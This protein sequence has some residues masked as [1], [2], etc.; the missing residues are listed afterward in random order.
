MVAFSWAGEG[1]ADGTPLDLYVMKVDHGSPVR[2]TSLP[3]AECFP[4][5]SPD[6]TEIAF[7]SEDG[8]RHE[9]C[10][11]PVL[12]GTV[13]RLAV[14]PAQI[15]GLSWSP[16]GQSLAYAAGDTREAISRIRVLSLANLSVRDLTSPPPHG[17]GDRS[18]VFSPD[19]R[20]VAFVRANG[21]REQDALVVPTGGGEA[22]RVEMGG[23]RVSGID[24][25]SPRELVISAAS[26]IDYGLWRVRVGSGE[27]RRMTV[28]AGRI[29]RVSMARGGRRLAYE[30]ISFARDIRCADRSGT[31]VVR[32]RPEPL[33]TSTQRQS[34][35]VF[36]PDGR[37]IAFVSDRSGTPEIW[38]AD[39]DGRDPRRITDHEATL[40]TTPRW[41]P[42]GTQVAYTCDAGGTPTVYV[43]ALASRVARRLAPGGTQVLSTWSRHGDAV[44]YQ[45]DTG[46]GWEVWRVRADGG[47]P[48]KIGEADFAVIDETADGQ[49]LLGVVSGEPGIW[50]VPVAG[51]PKT[52]VVPGELC[53]DWQEAIVAGDGMYFLRR[54]TARFTLGFLRF[55]AVR[56]DSL[57]SLEWYAASLALS[58]DRSR[59]LYD[60]IGGV[61]D[62][63]MVADFRK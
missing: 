57:G 37:S 44:Y 26:R 43:A 33:I 45:V 62:D 4:S 6:N 63:V 19:G 15:L 46:R 16:D 42:D 39:S 54:G 9:L 27:Q 22:R 38:V 3:G 58:P 47:D 53:R 1:A 13:R 10:T 14:V 41:S 17:Q 40:L 32:P 34:E 36:S 12:G 30:K 52:L 23:Q 8:D 59:F 11:V 55:G 61:E 49:G 25:L 20:N 5:W 48:R 28:P 51:G 50:R 60:C 31:G 2:L 24:W 7:A 21:L 18:P 29:Q 56:A 35:P